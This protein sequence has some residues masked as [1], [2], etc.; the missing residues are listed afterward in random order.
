MKQKILHVS[1]AGILNIGVAPIA[2]N[3]LATPNL[4]PKL[5]MNKP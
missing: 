4:Q 5:L 2:E 1:I 3:I